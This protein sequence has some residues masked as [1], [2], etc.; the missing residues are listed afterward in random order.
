MLAQHRYPVGDGCPM[1]IDVSLSQ[2]MARELLATELQRLD[3]VI[4]G[5]YQNISL[6][7]KGFLTLISGRIL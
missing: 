1:S 4:V 2:I 5:K 7:D 3:Y 6:A